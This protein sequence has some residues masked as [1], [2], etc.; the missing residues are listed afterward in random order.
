MQPHAKKILSGEAYWAQQLLECITQMAQQ[1]TNAV[2]SILAE[3]DS[4]KVEQHYPPAGLVFANDR[5]RAFYHCHETGALQHEH[6]HFHIF[7]LDHDAQWAHAVALTMDVDGQPVQW[8]AL[9]RWVTAGPW[10]MRAGFNSQFNSYADISHDTL[11]A[12]W[13]YAMLQTHRTQLDDL[14]VQR[15][16]QVQRHAAGG[17]PEQVFE[18]RDVYTLATMPVSL[19]ALLQT[20]LLS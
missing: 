11:V 3:V 17:N 6:G 13:L 14:L 2:L 15:D 20:Q 10:L 4:V 9:N 16:E 1:G 8:S 5:W 7:T 19:Q 18:T 12:R